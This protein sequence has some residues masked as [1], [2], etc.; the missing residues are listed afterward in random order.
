MRRADRAA[1]RVHDAQERAAGQRSGPRQL[2]DAAGDAATA[3]LKA[4][5]AAADEAQARLAAKARMR[6]LELAVAT[7]RAGGP[8]DVS[9]PTR[10]E[11][12]KLAD[13]VDP[14]SSGASIVR[15]VG[16]IVA[17]IAALAMTMIGGFGW[18]GVVVPLAILIA[19]GSLGD[20][21]RIADRSR[22]AGRI[23]LDL[24]RASLAPTERARG[25][26]LAAGAYGARPAPA[27]GAPAVAASPTIERPRFVE[28]GVPRTRVGV[29]AVLDRLVENV[30]GLLPE[31]DVATVRRI[32][33]SAALAL[34]TTDGPLDLTDHETW[35]L[36]QI[37]IDYLPGALEHFIA[38][39]PD[40]ASEPV[41]DGRSARQVLDEQLALIEG[42]LGEMATRTYR[43]EAGGL[44]NH[45]RFVADSLRPDPFQARLAKLA[46]K[47][48]EP[49]LVAA[50]EHRQ[51]AE[52]SVAMSEAAARERERA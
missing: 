3:A 38:L 33:D 43:R 24:A 41:L 13:R 32:R 37:C 6:E 47:D 20:R 17:G 34:P 48:L 9:P 2:V 40:L 51:A 26:A 44:L 36:R 4:V 46:V 25:V 15:G 45:A 50:P 27:R 8:V 52:A 35:L 29:V 39:P 1:R 5:S 28:D 22:K 16:F 49:I 14:G 21:V 30:R 12:L 19:G 7:A 23:Q 42:R 10:D 31:T 18:L 11:A